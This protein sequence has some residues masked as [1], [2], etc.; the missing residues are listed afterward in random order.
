V[1]GQE[2]LKD[3][4][5]PGLDLVGILSAD[6]SL[7]RPGLTSRERAVNAWFEA[8]AWA[9]PDGRVI[10][11]TTS[12]NDPAIQAL[13]MARPER[14]HRAESARRAEAG[15]P[16][17]APVFRI[18]GTGELESAL[19]ALPHRTLLGTAAEGA[20]VCLL[21]LDPSDLP[22]FGRAVRGLAERGVVTRVEAEPHL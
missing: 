6:A 8:A 20:T 19:E 7:R 3:A 4:G 5:S 22:A 11:Q 2:V 1:G 18:A 10:V 15:F 14:F 16:A 17:G 9:R 12:P 13:V 21:A